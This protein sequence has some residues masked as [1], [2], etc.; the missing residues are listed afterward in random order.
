MNLGL[1]SN[2]RA[3]F[4]MEFQETSRLGREIWR[5]T[6]KVFPYTLYMYIDCICKQSN[7]MII[8]YIYRISL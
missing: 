6:S 5:C 2:N 3:R 1:E 7:Y 4:C 8:S